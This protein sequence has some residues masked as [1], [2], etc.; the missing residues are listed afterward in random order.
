MIHLRAQGV[1][2]LA[3]CLFSAQ[4]Q[5]EMPLEWKINALT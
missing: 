5:A 4:V 3:L 1:L 2:G